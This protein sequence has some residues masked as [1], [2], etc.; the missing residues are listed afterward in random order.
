MV[1]P[2]ADRALINA[3]TPFEHLQAIQT[4]DGQ[5][6][7]AHRTRVWTCVVS[8]DG[9]NGRSRYA[10]QTTAHNGV[11]PQPWL[12]GRHYKPRSSTTTPGF[13]LT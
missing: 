12:I 8:G 10:I 2:A 9:G 4:P 5:F 13:W 11:R 6:P 1:D 7:L 3:K